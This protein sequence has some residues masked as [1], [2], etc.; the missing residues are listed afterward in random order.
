MCFS[1]HRDE[2]AFGAILRIRL[3]NFQKYSECTIRPGPHMNM[4]LGP[5]GTGK[6]TLVAAIALGLGFPTSVLGRSNDIKE[7]I[8]HGEEKSFIELVIKTGSDPQRRE[9]AFQ[10]EESELHALAQSVYSRSFITIRRVIHNANGKAQNEWFLN[11]SSVNHRLI[12]QIARVLRA[13]VDNM[14]QFLPQDKVGDFVKMNPMQM[15]EATQEA[16]ALPGTL[17]K[18]R[19]LIGLRARDRE[20]ESALE[21]DRRQMRE[22]E[23]HLTALHER[24]RAA[25]EARDHV[26]KLRNLRQKRPWLKYKQ[27]REDFVAKKA[28]RNAAKERLERE[29]LELN[30]DLQLQMNGCETEQKSLAKQ[31]RTIDTQRARLRSALEREAASQLQKNI[32]TANLKSALLNKRA[33]SARN[34]M[35]AERCRDEL[36]QMEEVIRE[37]Q[38]EL[39]AL[40]LNGTE[41]EAE[42]G[43]DQL[44]IISSKLR[45]AQYERDKLT[46]ARDALREEG[47]RHQDIIH[48]ATRQ[49][50]KLDDQ[51]EQKQERLRKINLDAFKALQWLESDVNRGKFRGQVL[52]PLCMEVTVGGDE[53]SCPELARMVESC[54][55]RQLLASFIFTEREDHELFMRECSDDRR[56]RINCILLQNLERLNHAC[57]WKLEDLK[58]S[59]FD[60]VLLNAL[61]GPASVLQ[62]LCEVANIH[63][64]PFCL[65]SADACLDM[66]ACEQ[67]PHLNKFVA[68]DGFFELRRSRYAPG[69]VANRFS[70]LKNELY[71]SRAAGRENAGR[72][73]L[74]TR[75]DSARAQQSRLEREMHQKL[76]KAGN[77]DAEIDA[78]GKQQSKLTE[79]RRTRNAL[80]AML[81]AKREARDGQR[82]R[83]RELVKKGAEFDESQE[84]ADLRELI[85]QQTQLFSKI[86]AL[87]SEMN[88]IL[89]LAVALSVQEQ[90]LSLQQCHLAQI[91]ERNSSSNEALKIALQQADNDLILAKA[92]AEEALLEHQNTATNLDEGMFAEVSFNW[93]R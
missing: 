26:Q 53:G 1:L 35:Q 31:K 54:I 88:E 72:Q 67:N 80:M 76:A 49:L 59:G 70:Q 93:A 61:Q 56:L 47:T 29:T 85:T 60:G 48:E 25:Q 11:D 73:E 14:C 17:E 39:D 5:N 89:M 57:P 71:L 24:K 46:A 91:I 9:E 8:K 81:N 30:A 77:L 62:A 34:R 13:Q 69:E 87:Q 41:A 40:N 75:I 20:I 18:H 19:K 27:L 51:R 3:K 55:S 44:K 64:I 63:K 15:L 33:A 22:D 12:V 82:R 4:V 10:D 45:D 7:F 32:Q 52:G 42:A 68:R 37:K 36:R 38:T 65:G 2:F 79:A 6:S 43:E 83:L 21:R 92:A 74:V 58:S 78:L 50:H 66:R 28:A 84:Q 16:A 90:C 86:Q 23:A